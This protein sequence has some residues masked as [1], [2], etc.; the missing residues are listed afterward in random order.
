MD[1]LILCPACE[2]EYPADRFNGKDVECFKCRIKTIGVA[3]GPAGKAFWHSTTNR[4]YIDKTV[5]QAKANGLDP[6][7]VR[8]ASVPVAAGTMKRLEKQIAPKGT[9]SNG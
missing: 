8:S 9:T 6:I 2:H 1:D 4:E 3:W 5:T 7:P